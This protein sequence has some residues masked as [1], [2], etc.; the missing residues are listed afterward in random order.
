MKYTI[1]TSP[2]KEVEINCSDH[3]AGTLQRLFDI[4]IVRTEVQPPGDL[5]LEFE[6]NDQL[7]I[8]DSEPSLE[9]YQLSDGSRTIVV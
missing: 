5:L 3:R 1:H 9:S 4:P 7:L 6:N 8:Y 2:V